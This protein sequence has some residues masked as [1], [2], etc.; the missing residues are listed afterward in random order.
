MKWALILLF[1]LL[2]LKATQGKKKKRH[3][4][5]KINEAHWMLAEMHVA[6]LQSQPK[7]LQHKGVQT[8]TVLQHLSVFQIL[9]Q[10]GGWIYSLLLTLLLSNHVFFDKAH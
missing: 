4:A 6:L 3:T 9:V 1:F 2:E 10:M 5:N 8:Q 7:H